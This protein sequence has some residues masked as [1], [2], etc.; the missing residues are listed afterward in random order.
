[1]SID[2]VFEVE[3]VEIAEN[4]DIADIADELVPPTEAVAPAAPVNTAPTFR[5]FELLPAVV[6]AVETRGYT[7]PTPIQAQIM[8]H[9]LAGRD[10]LAQSQT[11]TGKTAAFALPVLSRIN[12]EQRA[13][14]VLVLAPTRELAIQVARSFENY[15]SNLNDFRVAAIYGGQDYEIQF[16]ALRNGVQVVVGTPGRVID[17]VKRGTLD[18]SKINCLVLDE[19]DEMLNMGFLEDVQFLLQHAPEDRQIALFSATM[20]PAI[21]DIAND[22]LNDPAEIKIKRKTMTAE[23]IR[24]RAVFVSIRDKF[25]ALTRI[26]EA[27]E[28]DGVIIFT[29]TRE[30]TLQVA[31]QLCQHGHKAVALNGDM[32]QR[33][34]ERTIEQLK[35]GQLNILVATDVAARGLDVPRVS[36][37]FNYDLP[38]DSES[39]VHRIGRTGRAGRKGEA[40][41][42]LTSTQ[43]RKMRL[44]EQT[45]KQPIEEMSI[46]TA[47]EINANRIER[48]KKRITD[49][50]DNGEVELFE[51]MINEYAEQ[52]GQGLARVAAVLASLAQN[53]RD[54]FMSERRDIRSDSRPD[55][56]RDGREGSDRSE[57]PRRSIEER[58]RQAEEGMV[59]YR[60]EVGHRDGV[61][62]GNIVGAV[63]NE[64]GLDSAHIGHIAIYNDFSTIDLPEGMPREIFQIL[65]KTWVSGKKLQISVDSKPSRGGS[66]GRPFKSRKP[67]D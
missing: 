28:T 22:Y 59:R 10:L 14:Q 42:F 26:L 56:D 17:H 16:R 9:M 30:S 55:R 65:K 8:P 67:R 39:Y 7:H 45:T 46:P 61:R 52:T 50:M 58:R 51:K 25:D 31:D 21:Q 48:F 43:R 66:G 33:V 40:I 60:I 53:G 12:M 57:R 44:I 49:N 32:A 15:A 35:S 18:L 11:G 37:V 64:A 13:P 62:P 47:K 2:Q 41:I 4:V 34:R 1:M 29:K 5:D 36:H 54:F 63:A 38:H 20:P 19:A 6:D 24:Q 3:E 23:S 27:E